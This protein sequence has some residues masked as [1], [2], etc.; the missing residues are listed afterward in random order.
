MRGF[1]V[2]ILDLGMSPIYKGSNGHDSRNKTR[3]SLFRT[4]GDRLAGQ[5]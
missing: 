4:R 3:W 2:G 5:L 1:A